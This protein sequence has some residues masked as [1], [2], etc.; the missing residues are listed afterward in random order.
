VVVPFIHPYKVEDE[1]KARGVE[2]R[3]GRIRR[4]IRTNPVRGDG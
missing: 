3:R 1:I 4:I 2:L